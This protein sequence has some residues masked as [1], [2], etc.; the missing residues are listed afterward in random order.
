MQKPHSLR[1]ALTNAVQ[2][3][4]ENPE[5]L[6]IFVDNGTVVSTLAPSL[7]WEYRYTLNI[8]VTDFAGDQNLLIA[9]ILHWLR[10]NQPDIMA[11]PDNREKGFIFEVDMLN[12]QACDISIDL[13]L[14]ER[15]QV[16]EQNG[17]QVVAAL[18]EPDEP[19]EYWT[20]K[21]G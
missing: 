18:P 17:N 6:H 12:H 8:V 20:L 3:L 14:T 13:K 11:N 19:E 1:N 2:H 9:P 21:R 7:S 4:R 5:C 16:Q 15:I 10:D